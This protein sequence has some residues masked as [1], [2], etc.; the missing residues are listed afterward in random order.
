LTRVQDLL[1]ALHHHASTFLTSHD[2][3]SPPK[4]QKRYEQWVSKKRLLLQAEGMIDK[5]P[6]VAEREKAKERGRGKG[7]Y[8]RR[9]MWGAVE[10]EGLIALGTWLARSMW[11]GWDRDWDRSGSR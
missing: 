5:K 9:E 8:R 11:D 1:T 4:R 7:K 6:S 3:L 10:G 2:L